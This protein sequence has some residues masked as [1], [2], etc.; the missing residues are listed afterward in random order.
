MVSL[1]PGCSAPPGAD[2]GR[3][4]PAP[5]RDTVSARHT[6][7]REDPPTGGV[8]VQLLGQGR[9]A[10]GQEAGGDKAI[11]AV[12]FEDATAAFKSGFEGV[13]EQG[14]SLAGRLRARGVEGV[15][16]VG[17]ATDHRVRATA[18]DAVKAGVRARVGLD[19]DDGVAPN[20]INSTLVD[21]R[22]AGIAVSG[23]APV[24]Q[25]PH[26]RSRSDHRQAAVHSQMLFCRP[27]TSLGA[28]HRAPTE[29]PRVWTPTPEG[30]GLR[31]W[32]QAQ[33]RRN[34][35]ALG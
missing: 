20:T 28:A 12:F 15:D 17:I 11:D 5:L 23:E 14:T 3:P 32:F 33:P 7:Q 22:D 13:D 26:R 8:H 1:K 4:G 6:P 18:L 21:F 24:P 2:P 30:T 25:K 16:V 29:D 34:A 9:A 19:H 35:G 31:R 10:S 27:G